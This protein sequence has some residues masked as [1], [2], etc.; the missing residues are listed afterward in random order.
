MQL[1]LTYHTAQHPATGLTPGEILFSHG[2]RESYPKRKK[3]K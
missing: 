1:P 3:M 2:D